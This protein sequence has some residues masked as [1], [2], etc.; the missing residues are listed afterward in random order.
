MARPRE[1]D[2]H[3]AIRIATALFWRKGYDGTSLTDLEKAI[4][5]KTPSFYAAFGSKEGLFKK[6]LAHYQENHL[7]YFAE[8]LS[9]P[10]AK[11]VAEKLLFG[12]ADAHSSSK[13][14]PGCLAL[15]C[16]LP[17]AGSG[18]PVR[19]ELAKLRERTRAEVTKR[20]RKAKAEGDLPENAHP[21]GLARYILVVG[22][23]MA[24]E[25]Q[26][27]ATGKDLHRIA[28]TAMEAF[29]QFNKHSAARKK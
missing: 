7:Q 2:V 4:G 14:P 5:I 25:A 26:S 12:L 24:V 21:E 6:V 18:D 11:E 19:L 23:G 20:F 29:S 3:E 8:A 17:V 28:E 13:H 9:A 15:N 16:S 22:Y 27:G 1:F 10:T